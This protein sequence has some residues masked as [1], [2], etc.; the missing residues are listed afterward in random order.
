M[1]LATTFAIN[2]SPGDGSA[3]VWDWRVLV[4]RVSMGWSGWFPWLSVSWANSAKP[5]SAKPDS[6]APHAVF[7]FQMLQS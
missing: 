5:D 6:V 2:G 7:L 1:I 4:P 3:A